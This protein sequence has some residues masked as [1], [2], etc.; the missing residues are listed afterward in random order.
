MF[1]SV[2][3]LNGHCYCSHLS[4]DQAVFNKNALITVIGCSS[5]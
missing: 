4:A 2:I 3:E 1:L 5:W